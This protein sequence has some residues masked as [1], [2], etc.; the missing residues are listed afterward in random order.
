MGL[1]EMVNPKKPGKSPE[2]GGK[3]HGNNRATTRQQ[4]R[5]TP[6]L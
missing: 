4:G 2:T 3:E 5:L 6:L 1:R